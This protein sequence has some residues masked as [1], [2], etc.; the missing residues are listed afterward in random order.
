MM[1]A[2][3]GAQDNICLFLGKEGVNPF[4]C[5]Q[6]EPFLIQQHIKGNEDCHDELNS[7]TPE[8]I[9][10]YGNRFQKLRRIL[11]NILYRG[12]QAVDDVIHIRTVDIHNPVEEILDT[13]IHGIGIGCDVCCE[14]NDGISYLRYKINHNPDRTADDDDVVD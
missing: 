7:D 9:Y 14:S 13:H 6:A 8:A 4:F 3:S 11:R 5:L 12:K 10:I 2:N 1:R